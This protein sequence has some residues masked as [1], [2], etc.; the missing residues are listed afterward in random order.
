MTQKLI[1]RHSVCKYF[2]HMKMTLSNTQLLECAKLI[3]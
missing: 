2:Q 3:N 1:V